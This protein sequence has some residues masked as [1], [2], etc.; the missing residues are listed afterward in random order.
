VVAV[1]DLEIQYILRGLLV[2]HPK[3]HGLLR[4]VVQQVLAV[5]AVV[6]LL[7]AQ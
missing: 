4:Q 1:A 5:G 2:V 3:Q 7:L 6:L